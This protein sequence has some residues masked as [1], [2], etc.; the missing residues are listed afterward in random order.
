MST[1]LAHSGYMTGRHLK[2]LAR[3]PWYLAITLVQPVIWLLLFGALF[4]RVVEI[5]GFTSGSYADYLTPGIAVMSVVF[6][7]GWSGMGIIEDID[8]GVLNH[9]LVSPV[10]RGGLIAGRVLYQAILTVIQTAIILALGLIVG[11]RFTGGASSVVVFVVAAVLL[12]AGIGSLSDML[13]LLSRKQETMIGASQFV[14]LPLTFISSA[15]MPTELAPGW[16]QTA[17]RYN[18]VDWAVQVGHT[19]LGTGSLDWSLVLSRT[20]ALLA[21]TLVCSWLAVR[22]FR[23]Y[24]RSA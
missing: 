4:R 9:W 1:A 8:R 6:S 3:Q 5:P 7:A 14:V 13:G 11:A 15:F 21:F 12:G 22:A 2:A 24:Q 19:A 23:S 18:P 10:R 16:I 17:A 20:G